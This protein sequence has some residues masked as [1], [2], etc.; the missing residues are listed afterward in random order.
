[1]V[2]VAVLLTYDEIMEAAR[3]LYKKFDDLPA[4]EQQDAV[5]DA[6]AHRLEY[7]AKGIRLKQARKRWMATRERFCKILRDP[8]LWP[9]KFSW[10]FR[11]PDNCAMGLGRK[12]GFYEVTCTDALQKTFG[13]T[14]R[15]SLVVFV[16][17]KGDVNNLGEWM[18][19]CTPEDVALALE[20]VG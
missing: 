18:D 2:D 5:L 15:E 8:S 1:M 12:T 6:T 14:E 4:V 10:D 7:R 19:D 13:L 11:A 17:P 9:K 3:E 20:R 16:H